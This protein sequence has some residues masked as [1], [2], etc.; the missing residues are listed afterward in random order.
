[1]NLATYFVIPQ[2]I[3]AAYV[4]YRLLAQPIDSTTPVAVVPGHWSISRAPGGYYDE[5]G[6]SSSSAAWGSRSIVRV[7]LRKVRPGWEGQVRIVDVEQMGDLG[8]GEVL[9]D[10]RELVPSALR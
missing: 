9:I 6:L 1:M 2:E 10:M 5:F 4:E 8:E 7:A 3:E